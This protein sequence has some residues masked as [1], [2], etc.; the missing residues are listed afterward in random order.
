MLTDFRKLVRTVRGMLR[1][2]LR[3]WL[4]LTRRHSCHTLSRSLGGER[5]KKSERARKRE[6]KKEKEREMKFKVVN[7]RI[8]V[9]RSNVMLRPCVSLTTGPIFNMQIRSRQQHITH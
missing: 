7:H 2:T 4:F 8:A 9:M 3:M 6:R 1:F 5:H